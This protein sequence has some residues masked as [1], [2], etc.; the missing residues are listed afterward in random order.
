MRACSR[1]VAGS[2]VGDGTCVTG[3]EIRRFSDVPVQPAKAA[4]K[5]TSS[6]RLA[7]P[8][9]RVPISALRILLDAF[10][11]L[12]GHGIDDRAANLLDPTAHLNWTPLP[13]PSGRSPLRR[14]LADDA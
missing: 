3:K 14:I 5:A 12:R 1:C 7:N 2:R 11:L 8:D 10:D 9:L 13:T 6:A 4:A